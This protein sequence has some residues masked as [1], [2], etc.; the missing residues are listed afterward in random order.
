MVEGIDRELDEM[1][2]VLEK[3]VYCFKCKMRMVMVDKATYK[4]PKCSQGYDE[5]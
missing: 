2:V 4:C 3:P 5:R 1:G